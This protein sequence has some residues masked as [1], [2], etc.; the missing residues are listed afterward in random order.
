[1]DKGRID[2]PQEP[3]KATELSLLWHISRILN[4]SEAIEDVIE[5]VLEALARDMGMK[6]GTLAL[7]NR[8]TGEITIE[9]AHGLSPDEKERG[10]YKIGEG[11]TGAVVASG[12]PIIVP[13]IS[14]EPLFLNRTGAREMPAKED[15]S[16]IC[17]PIKIKDEVVGTLSVDRLFDENVALEEDMRLISVIAAMVA[18][19]VKRRGRAR[20]EETD[21]A[22]IVDAAKEEAVST[23][24]EGVDEIID[25]LRIGDNV[26]WRVDDIGEFRSLAEYFVARA[27]RDGRDVHY[28]R[29]ADHVPLIDNEHVMTHL[30][31]PHRGFE[32]FSIDIYT[33]ITRAGERAF[34]VFDS[35]SYLQTAWATDLMVG[36]FFMIMCPYLFE[37]NTV[38]YFAL[39]QN[40]HSFQ[41]VSRIRNI[42]QVMIDA[43][44]HE[45]RFYVHPLKVWRRRSPS[46]YSLHMRQGNHFV[47]LE[48]ST[49]A[50]RILIELSERKDE[51]AT[52]TLDYWDR[53]FL[54]AENLLRRTAPE[55]DQRAMMDTLSG[56]MM[57]REPRMQLLI[58]DHFTLADLLAV[59]ARMI[60]TGFIGGKAAG[61]LLARKMLA[62]DTYV[63]WDD[64]LESHDSFFIGS[65]VFYSYLVQ[66]GWWKLL[67]EQR[68]DRGYHAVAP[69]LREKMTE[70]RFPD[71][72]KEQ[73]FQLIEYFGGAPIIVRS[74]SLLEDSFGNAFAGKYESIFLVNQGSPDERYRAFEDAVRRVYASTMNEDALRYRAQRGLQ[75]KDEQMALLVQRVSGVKRN[76]VFF[77]DLAGVGI[78][79]NTFV[80]KQ[81]MDPQAGMLRLV[82][83]LGTRAV[84]RVETDYPRIVALDEPLVKPHG[85]IADTRKF[86]QREVD[87]LNIDKNT[88]ATEKLSAIADTVPLRFD[89]FGVPDHDTM[90]F[91]RERGMTGRTAW[92]LTFD[93]LLSRT[94]FARTM[95]RMLKSLESGF[96]YPVDMEFTVNYTGAGD[97]DYRVNLVQCRPLQTVGIERR[98]A[99][100]RNVAAERIFF[101]LNGNFMGGSI[102]ERIRWVIYIEPQPYAGLSQQKRYDVARVIGRLNGA[103]GDR[104]EMPTMLLG[105]GRWG[106][107][108][109]SLGVPVS[110]SEINNMAVLGEVAYA[111]GNLIP[112]L[113]YGSH[114]FQD[115]VET[116]IFYVA[117]FPERSDTVFN[118][119]LVTALPNMLTDILPD[120]ADCGEIVRVCDV[121][122]LNLR[123]ASDVVTQEAVCYAEDSSR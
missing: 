32:P 108:T 29:F 22:G 71:E 24:F 42:T 95:Q 110:F 67:V 112:E 3:P 83:G 53:L 13:R 92:I 12:E 35:L 34:Y 20:E 111:E 69:M 104:S 81:G 98:Q 68:T 96:D 23:G 117:L 48:N 103:I 21:R 76:G 28:I 44:R 86:S 64:I 18:E 43:Y 113:S 57:S 26:V 37:L 89:L 14:R 109:P 10:R 114:F 79:Y 61:M 107:S 123:I 19:A 97:D 58:K 73:F 27:L 40:R 15:I 59:R 85:G 106:T 25:S 99:M 62:N 121:T 55:S 75:K 36:N 100:P 116:G 82:L 118:P 52:M 72:I 11:V 102:A 51:S 31:D 91:M 41:T 49:E 66:N 30:L 122:S 115:L 9:A 39:L 1:V 6:R 56:I 94:S 78:S 63:N 93:E 74:S 90:E 2:T 5:P 60:G 101:R 80:W 45:R 4:R 87:C 47:P 120:S 7:V 8:A 54:D 16:F 88:F 50:A 33:I 119:S 70:G 65:D 17:V 84:N 46:M 105:P 77:P 38:A